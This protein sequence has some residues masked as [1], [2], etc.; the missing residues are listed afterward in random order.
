MPRNSESNST[1]HVRSRVAR[2]HVKN[3]LMQAESVSHSVPSGIMS[4][5]KEAFASE[6]LIQPPAC[7]SSINERVH[8]SRRPQVRALWLHWP[9]D[10]VRRGCRDAGAEWEPSVAWRFTCPIACT[11]A[12]AHTGTSAS[13]SPNLERKL[14]ALLCRHRRHVRS[15][16]HTSEHRRQGWNVFGCLKRHSPARRYDVVFGGNS[17]CRN[18]NGRGDGWC[19]FRVRHTGR[20]TALALLGDQLPKPE[21]SRFHWADSSNACDQRRMKRT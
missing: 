1:E 18:R 14:A 16:H 21:M 6:P 3:E 11:R 10:W 8:T 13:S 12:G 20:L 17:F 5:C 4:R 15:C 9:T 19:C 7:V 2:Q